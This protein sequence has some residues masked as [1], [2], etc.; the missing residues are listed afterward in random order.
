[1]VKS[2]HRKRVRPA[3]DLDVV[4]G[5]D[6]KSASLRAL[7]IAAVVGLYGT[8]TAAQTAADKPPT[9]APRSAVIYHNVMIP[10][11]DGVRLA[12][13]IYMPSN[14]GETPTPG[15][16]SVLLMRTPYGKRSMS[17]YPTTHVES[18][19]WFSLDAANGAGYVVVYQD[20]RG[21]FDSE[22]TLQPMLNEAK[23]GFDTVEWLRKQPWS[24]GRI[25][26]FGGSYMGGDQI[27]LAAEHPPGLVT[28]FSTVAATD[29]FRNAGVYMDGVLALNTA[30]P[31][32]AGMVGGVVSRLPE[33]EQKSLKA[34]YAAL[35]IADPAAMKP[36]E[37]DKLLW[38]LPLTEMLIVRRAPW[39]SDWLSNRDNPRYFENSQMSGRFEKI[40]VPIL[41]LGG[42]YDL[43]LRNT[44]E[45]FK[46][47]STRAKD[48]RVRADQR[49]VI[50]P[51]SHGTCEGCEP[52][53]AVNAEAMQL[54][55]MDQW[56]KGKKHPFFE[57]PVVLYVMGENRWRSEESWPLGGTVRT[58]YYL[59]SQGRANSASGDGKLL[60]SKPGAEAPDRYSYDPRN[61]A[62]TLGGFGPEGGRALQNEAEQ[63]SDLVVFTSP[64]L[65]E[66][67][68]V[69]GEVTATLYAASSA[70]DT[71][72]WVKL[73][74]VAPDGKAYNLNQ[75]VVRARYRHSRTQPEALTP[76][77]I[78]RYEVD[79]WATS[80]V[81]GKGH[82][83]RVEVTSS[84]FPYADRNPNA[85]VDLSRASEKD[86]VVAAQTIFHDAA[87]PSDVELPIIPPSHARKWID[88][89][90]QKP[91]AAR[92]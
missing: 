67:V 75:G 7:S 25:A 11:R 85:F 39:W 36:A 1:M 83:I 56:F 63:R 65:T 66:D 46:G 57:Y 48:Q 19:G 68:E 21:T 72:W 14:E 52:N 77:K 60:T 61:P 16:F 38:T 28:A 29:P 79:M 15:R 13:D 34:D 74:D 81:F 69:T 20:V 12:T 58:P 37:L 59:H 54:A 41:H 8:G 10:M 91:E 71:D 55:W 9:A 90:F 70:K 51:W 84:N 32:T 62:P 53:A 22:G 44:Y 30:A 33:A 49:L 35:G 47:I 18:A 5:N 80:N 24:D 50:G 26:T 76:G 82:C 23:D 78:E 4:V 2:I 42:W 3:D 17:D 73:V 89:P 45:H 43:F 6:M 87:H 64:I 86:F 27:L 40:N 31:W 88:T 92:H